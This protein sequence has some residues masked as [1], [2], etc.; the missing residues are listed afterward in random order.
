M[1]RILLACGVI[2]GPLYIIVGLAQAFTR[3]GFDLRRHALSMLSIG[4]QGWVQIANF[5][6]TGALTTAAA[7]GMWRVLHPSGVTWAPLLLGLYGI[8]LVAA[9]IFVPDAALGFPPGTPAGPP[10]HM[11]THGTMHFVAGGVGFLGL[12]AACLLFARQFARDGQTGWA[13]YSAATGVLFLAGFMGIASGAAKPS[14]NLSFGAA[15][16]LV[17]VWISALSARL[18]AGLPR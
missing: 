14:I 18:M 15:V 9:G 5:V 3:E 8:G 13:I 6:L 11:T 4:P 16:V 17:C 1:N 7:A 2:A 12:I 10:A